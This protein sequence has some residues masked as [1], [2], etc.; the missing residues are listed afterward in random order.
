MYYE[1]QVLSQ[2]PMEHITS[3]IELLKKAKRPLVIIGKGAAYSK[4]E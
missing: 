1:P 2:A 4:A 3:A